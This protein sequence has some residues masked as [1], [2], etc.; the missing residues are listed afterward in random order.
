MQWC[1]A[2]RSDCTR[3]SATFCTHVRA[4]TGNSIMRTSLLRLVYAVAAVTL[5]L[6]ASAEAQNGVLKVT[7]FPSGAA[8]AVD[9]VATGKITPMSVTLPTGTHTVIV[10]ISG[11]GW[12]PI[13]QTVTVA[14]GSSNE[15]S[16]TLVPSLTAGPAGPKGDK[17]DPGPP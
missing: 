8:V 11:A 16:V 10:S 1:P 9:G 4:V 13:T 3:Q 17:G 2:P 6:V 5:A 14:A 7:S 12:S 15:I